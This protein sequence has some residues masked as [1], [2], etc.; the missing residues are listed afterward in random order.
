MTGHISS[1]WSQKLRRHPCPFSFP[2]P[3]HSV[4]LYILLSWHLPKTSPTCQL[5][6]ISTSSPSLA[7]SMFY[8]ISTLEPS[9][10]NSLKITHCVFSGFL[11]ILKTNPSSSSWPGMCCVIHSVPNVPSSLC[12]P[13]PF[14]SQLW[15]AWPSLV[16]WEARLSPSSLSNLGSSYS[17][18]HSWLAV[19][20]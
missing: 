14:L 17:H 7:I 1:Y 4:D 16:T 11:L 19:S 2:Y 3:S 5:L 10:Q 20:F 13:F 12:A 15:S 8:L 9:K 6:S 18:F